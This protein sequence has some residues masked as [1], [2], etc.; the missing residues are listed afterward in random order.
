MI[1]NTR[2]KQMKCRIWTGVAALVVLAAC[3]GGA[4]QTSTATTPPT[5]VAVALHATI[6]TIAP[7]MVITPTAD[8]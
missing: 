8:A 5:S 3:G 7:T 2:N 4:E 6:E 1:G